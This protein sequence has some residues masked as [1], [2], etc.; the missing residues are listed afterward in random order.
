MRLCLFQD[1]QPLH[2]DSTTFA[3]FGSLDHISLTTSRMGIF[4]RF[5]KA[6]QAKPSSQEKDHALGVRVV[7]DALV[8]EGY[9][10]EAVNTDLEKLPQIVASIQGRLTFFVVR[11]ARGPLPELPAETKRACEAQAVKF[12][13]TC[14]FAPVALMSTGERNADGEEG[15]FV[16]YRGY[17]NA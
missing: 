15:F 13:A 4:D 7:H 3:S 16:N 17:R 5:F 12:G 6:Q 14:M 2:G 11:V 10:I 9:T 8:K 1:R